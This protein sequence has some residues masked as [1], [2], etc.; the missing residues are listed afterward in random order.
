VETVIDLGERKNSCRVVIKIFEN[1][2]VLVFL[3]GHALGSGEDNHWFKFSVKNVL[4][5]TLELDR[6]FHLGQYLRR[7]PDADERQLM[8]VLSQQDL[9]PLSNVLFDTLTDMRNRVSETALD[10]VEETLNKA[11]D[12]NHDWLL[13]SSADSDTFEGIGNRFP[14]ILE[15]VLSLIQPVNREKIDLELLAVDPLCKYKIHHLFAVSISRILRSELGKRPRLERDALAVRLRALAVTA[16]LA[17]ST[18]YLISNFGHHGILLELL[19]LMRNEEGKNIVDIKKRIVEFSK[20]V[21]TLVGEDTGLA[22][23]RKAIDN[24]LSLL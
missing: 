19:G 9:E 5:R 2:I 13:R 16:P 24:P 23:M 3:L 7:N 6:I 12:F 14:L 22:K 21:E 8:H 11:R 4:I 18:S 1:M 20:Q 10:E 17:E 15:K